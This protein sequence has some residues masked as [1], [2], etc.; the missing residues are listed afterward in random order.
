[1]SNAA[2]RLSIIKQQ[3]NHDPQYVR[4]RHELSEVLVITTKPR[5]C[6]GKEVDI[7]IGYEIIYQPRLVTNRSSIQKAKIQRYNG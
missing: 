2:E 7:V 6:Q 5:L 4:C 1:M 3:Y